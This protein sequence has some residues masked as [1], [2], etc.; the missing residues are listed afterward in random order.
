MA[1]F[2]CVNLA[3]FASVM[4]SNCVHLPLNM[5]F[6]VSD[7]VGEERGDTRDGMEGTQVRDMV[8]GLPALQEMGG[9]G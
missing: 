1:A 3:R 7:K 4:S 6:R 8:G 5:D 9:E 2:V